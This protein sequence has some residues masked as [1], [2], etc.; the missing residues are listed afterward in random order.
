[1]RSIKTFLRRIRESHPP[2]EDHD[3]VAEVYSSAD[4]KEG[5]DAFL[6]K[7]KPNWQGR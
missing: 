4:F 7:R 2:V 1:M 3:I 5:M 6:S